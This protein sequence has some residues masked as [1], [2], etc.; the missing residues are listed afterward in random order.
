MKHPLGRRRK[1]RPFDSLSRKKRRN[2]VIHIRRTTPKDYPS[3]RPPLSLSVSVPDI[4]TEVHPLV[5]M[6]QKH[7]SFSKSEPY[8]S[9]S[10][11]KTRCLDI[12]VSRDSLERA[13]RIMDALLKALE[14]EGMYVKITEHGESKIVFDEKETEFCLRE[15]VYTE[16]IEPA[17]PRNRYDVFASRTQYK[18]TS[19]GKLELEIDG[20]HKLRSHWRDTEKRQLEQILGTF[21]EGVQKNAI[22]QRQERL[23]REEQARRYREEQRLR[24]EAR[25][26]EQELEHQLKNYSYAETL[27]QYASSLRKC[28]SN[29]TGREPEGD[30][31]AWID[32]IERRADEHDP[33]KGVIDAYLLQ[34]KADTEKD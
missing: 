7:L 13:L 17:P 10:P 6:A 28:V 8:H 31:A 14:Q 30:V 9:C 19:S 22:V 3:D 16:Q 23:R 1:L 34:N 26:R 25:R 29:A 18:Y 27:R 2:E 15:M 32:W 11:E 24:E 5:E 21:I 33:V 12:R 20:Q 4:L